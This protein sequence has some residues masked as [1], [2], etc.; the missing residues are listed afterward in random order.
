MNIEA[1]ESLTDPEWDDF[2]RSTPGGDHLQS[3]AWARVKA[4]RGW[5]CLRLV[6]VEAGSICAGM[7]ILFRPLPVANSIGYV[8]KGPVIASGFTSQVDGMLDAMRTA[9][10][11][12][13]IGLIF[14][15]LPRFGLG[16]EADLRQSGFR[17]SRFRLGLSGTT[18]VDL[19]PE[20]EALLA[21]M[22][23]SS[24]RNVR[25]GMRRGI[26]VRHGGR[27]DISAF[28]RLLQATAARQSFVADPEIAFRDMWEIM[29]P[30]GQAKLLI[31]EYEGE[32]VSAAWLVPFGDTVVYKRGAWSGDHGQQRPNELL[33]W[34]AMTW[35]RAAGFAHYDFDGVDPPATASPR[36]QAG[37]LSPQSV[38]TFKLGFGGQFET[39]GGTYEHV[40]GPISS[41]AAFAIAGLQDRRIFKRAI[42]QSPQA[43]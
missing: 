12:L 25:L 5:R 1:R 31:A 40:G 16:L 28:Y 39:L 2:L 41:I 9:L 37:G 43:A 15:R 18:I 26:R 19:R 38:A 8:Q 34:S 42:K 29:A 22:H 24:R 10:R 20:P 30:V 14:L 13:G 11:R 32:P 17:T 21:A 6:M 36:G 35:A 7:Q 27:E 3:S 33:H 4:K 23:P